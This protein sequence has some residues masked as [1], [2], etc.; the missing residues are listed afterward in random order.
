MSVYVGA[1]I[2]LKVWRREID[3]KTGK[4]LWKG[5]GEL[6]ELMPNRRREW[7]PR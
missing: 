3:T 5:S 6:L 1:N 7:R 2:I 4:E